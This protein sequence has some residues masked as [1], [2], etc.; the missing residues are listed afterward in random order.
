MRYVSLKAPLSSYVGAIA[1]LP[2]SL[3]LLFLFHLLLLLFPSPSSCFSCYSLPPLLSP[4]FP[5]PFLN[6]FSYSFFCIPPSPSLSSSSSLLHRYLETYRAYSHKGSDA[7]KEKDKGSHY[8]RYNDSI[9][10]IRGTA[11]SS[12]STRLYPPCICFLLS[13]FSHFPSSPSLSP[14]PVSSF[15]ETLSSI[16]LLL[17]FVGV[18]QTD[19]LT[20]SRNFGNLSKIMSASMEQLVMCPG[21]GET[22]VCLYIY[23]K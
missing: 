14:P 5:F 12:P 2:G 11:I 19:A 20:L 21:L 23:A 10:T 1:R 18:N 9:T 17:L 13:P 7:I 8:A 16:L 4:H 3:S 15:R 22:K 6:P